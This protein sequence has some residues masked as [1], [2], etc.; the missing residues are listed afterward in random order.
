VAQI[1]FSWGSLKFGIRPIVPRC[2]ERRLIKSPIPCSIFMLRL[3]ILRHAEAVPH[4]TIADPERRLT[5]AGRD[6]SE[7]LG[8]YFR[9]EGLEPDI[10]LV[11]PSARTRETF[12]GLQCGA[13]QEIKAEFPPALYNA[14]CDRLI[15]LIGEAPEEAKFLLIVGHNPGFA[16]LAVALA[17]KGKKAELAKLRSHFPTPCLAVID[18]DM[19][20][21]K[22]AA[23]GE[24]RLEHFVTR[25]ALAKM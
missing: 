3:A 17:S 9:D 7:R 23:K 18:F 11:S 22:K 25:G 5:E 15:E 19:K 12:E 2:Y 13:K 4:G 14:T 10:A 24:G 6:M 16:E 21:W 20:S 1:P 8:R